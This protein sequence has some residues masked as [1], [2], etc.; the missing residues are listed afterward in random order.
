M[1]SAQQVLSSR[2]GNV[3]LVE[4]DRQSSIE[5]KGMRKL[6]PVR[7]SSRTL[8]DKNP[9][10]TK[11]KR[12]GKPW[13]VFQTPNGNVLVVPTAPYASIRDFAKRA[14]PAEWTRM[15][16]VVYTAR[17]A[18]EAR[19]GGHFYIETLGYH[20]PQLHI[21]LV[22]RPNVTYKL[23][24][25]KSVSPADR[26]LLLKYAN[27]KD[28][29]CARFDCSIEAAAP[30]SEYDVDI[31]FASPATIGEIGP[32]FES[33]SVSVVHQSPD[34]PRTTKAR[35]LFNLRN[36][37]RV[38]DNFRGTLTEYRKYLDQ[39]ELGHA[40]FHIWDHDHEKDAVGGVCPVMQQQTKG[41]LTCVPG[42]HNHPH[43]W[44]LRQDASTD[45]WLHALV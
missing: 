10:F 26:A 24:F 17:N 2:D 39:H 12:T 30:G 32:S 14:T 22:R 25:D 5:I 33:L 31:G 16:T 6:L 13:S 29:W 19:Y 15:W 7:P 27:L 36:W 3:R 44:T 4:N 41:T 21:R 37:N 43:T 11:A 9:W 18:L 35:T 40:L 34:G 28:G 20:V 42:V 8:F 1:I 45:A 23:K 38:P